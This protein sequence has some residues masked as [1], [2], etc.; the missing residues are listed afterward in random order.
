MSPR[1]LHID[2]PM[3]PPH[4]AL[5]QRELIRAEALA[6]REFFAHYFDE[7]GYLICVPRWGGDDGPD[8]AAENLLNWTMLHALGAPDEVLELYKKGWEGHLRQYTEE[9]TVDVPMGREGMYYKEFPVNFDWMHIGEGLNAFMLQG[10]SDP[11][12]RALE[13]R[14][15]RFTGF[16]TGDD[17][18]ADNYDP[19]HRIIRSMFNG[20]RGPMLRKAT[21]VDWAGD[22]IE[23]A[24]RFDPGHGE[25][26]Y[27]EML[28]HFQ[29]YNDV[30]GDHPL[31]LGAT[32]LAFNA[33]ALTGEHSFRDWALEYID[34]WVERTEAN[35]GLTPSN[36]GLDGSIGGETDG[37]WYGGVY[38]WGFSVYDPADKAI[39]HRPAMFNR[40]PYGFGNGLLLTGDQR[41]VDTWRGVIQAV[42]ANA[43]TVDGRTVYPRMHGD[44]GWYDFRYEPFDE[45]ALAVY[46]WSMVE[47]DRE[48]VRDDEWVQY[49]EG[50]NPG[51]ATEA[52]E[53]DL[54]AVRWRMEQVR[55]DTASADTR[56]SDDMNHL[57]PAVTGS[58][59]Q[60]M[61]GGLPT[62]RE[63]YPLHARVRYFDP[64][65]R[66]A[67]VPED[68]A[69][70]VTRMTAT[71]TD[72]T[73]VNIS[74]V[75][76]RTVVVQGGGYGEHQI[77][78]AMSGG[79]TLDVDA[80]AYTV[81]L[82]PGAG[83]N[84]TLTM[85]RYAN[86][87]SLEFPWNR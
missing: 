66:R 36:I 15:R 58:L 24:G 1:A 75:E 29:D 67:G 13:R 83:A 68:V 8:D 64:E 42:N 26:D 23:I 84:I 56:M 34:A 52:L 81:R 20:S 49:L 47:A 54:E 30:V 33:Y 82:A 3:T 79:Q 65:G 63:G 50:E 37:K 78:S 19:E 80:S 10:L 35:G 55:D 16:Y 46:Y 2:E 57:V 11:Y 69:A 76:S 5:L 14:T 41:Y 6:C 25:R 48:R 45:G 4:W 44:D 60:L 77:A 28:V 27:E 86:N 87:P 39:R 43:K 40:V 85:R 31:N 38:G 59:T 12:D 7:R 22:P 70:L 9:K 71:E 61:L 17:P 21:A 32:T 72:V 73:L 62:G 53:R 18:Q 74:Q 51:Y